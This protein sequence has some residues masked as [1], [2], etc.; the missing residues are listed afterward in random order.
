[1]AMVSGG[2]GAPVL[3]LEICKAAAAAAT[4]P[5]ELVKL[6]LDTAR[7]DPVAAAAK[8][9]IRVWCGAAT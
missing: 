6:L 5:A 4:G 8:L 1:M 3:K 9:D 7:G 2:S